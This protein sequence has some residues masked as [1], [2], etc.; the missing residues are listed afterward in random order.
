MLIMKSGDINYY[1]SPIIKVIEMH[2]GRIMAVS[3]GSGGTTE[4][5]GGER[6]NS[7]DPLFF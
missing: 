1:E 2:C 4:P 6:G 3:Q 7:I 5:G